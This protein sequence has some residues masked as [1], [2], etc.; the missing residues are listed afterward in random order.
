MP[1]ERIVFLVVWLALALVAGA[2]I[3]LAWN[4]L[5]AKSAAPDAA[6]SPN[7]AEHPPHG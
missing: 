4:W 1:I 5:G 2:L 7:R 3:V 6:P